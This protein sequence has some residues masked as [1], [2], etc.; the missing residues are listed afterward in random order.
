VLG[1]RGTCR[2][3]VDGSVLR[4]RPLSRNLVH[5]LH[6]ARAWASGARSVPECGTQI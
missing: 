6:D 5:N 2:L 1:M 3:L 4:R